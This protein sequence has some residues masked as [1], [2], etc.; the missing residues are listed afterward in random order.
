MPV[1]TPFDH[2]IA[3]AIEPF[4]PAVIS[5]HFGLPSPELVSRIK[6]WGSKILSTATTVQEAIWLESNGADAII[7]QGVEAG[8]HRGM[9]LSQDL[10]SQMGLMALLPQVVA[11]VNIPV[12]AAG[13]IGDNLGVEAA[14]LLGATAVQVGTAYL[15]CSETNTSQLHREA[16]KTNSIQSNTAITNLFTGHPARGI[17]NRVMKELSYINKAAPDFP[18]ASIEM[19]QL[20][21]KSEY[22]ASSDF[23]PLWCGQNTL[24][25]AEIS[26]QDLTLS[27]AGQR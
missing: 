12:I 26:A 14:L 1:E 27:L 9:F 23:S 24:G 22:K 8:G 25:C 5:F 2:N 20:R 3:D 13:G 10:S 15:L 7:V 18:Y 16:I 19:G 6:N 11:Q 17:I 21:L 4:S